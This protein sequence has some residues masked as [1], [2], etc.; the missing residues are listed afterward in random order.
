MSTTIL[1]KTKIGYK[2]LA[3][4]VIT[5]LLITAAAVSAA[6][7]AGA[8][9]TVAF[10][11]ANVAPVLAG[12]EPGAL[13]YAEGAAATSIT[14]NITVADA[15][16]ANMVSATVQITGNYVSTEDVLSFTNA[17]GI[18]GTWDV[19]TGTLTLTGSATKANYQTALRAVKYQN[20]NT[21]APSTTARTLSFTVNDGTVNSN[22][23]SR[24]IN[25]SGVNDAP[26]LSGIEMTNLAYSEGQA[27]T[28][29]TSSIAVSDVDNVNI[30]SATVVISAGF[31]SGKDVLAFTNAFGIT[32]SFSGSTL[33]LSGASSLANY[34]AALQSVTFQNN[35]NNNPSTTTRTI[36]F[37]VNDGA[38][39][40]TTL[41]RNITFTAVNDA[42]VLA[43][44]EAAALTFSEGGAAK[45]ISGAITAVD[46]DNANLTGATIQITGNFV[47]TEDVLSFTTANGITGTFDAATGTIALTG[48]ATVGNYQ[49]AL[50]NVLYK[51]TNTDNPSSSTRTLS[52]TVTDGTDA[53]NT[54]TRNITV[55]PVND[56]S[57]LSAVEPA[58]L[59]YT[60]DQGATTITS[61]L[62]IA[63]VDNTT[64]ASATV[65]INAPAYNASQDVLAFANAFGITGSFNSTTGI[66]TLTGVASLSDYE[67]ALRSVTYENTNH[68]A[69]STTTRAVAF[70]V[71]DGS[72]N[73][74]TMIRN[75]TIAVVND[76]PVL[77]AIESADMAYTEDQAATAMTT[78]QTASDGDNTNL[79]GAT[80]Q[81]T[82]NYVSTED[83]LSF[84]NA[85][86]IT[87]SF[88]ATTGTMTLTGSA[89]VVN[90]QNALRAVRYKNSNLATPSPATRTVSFTVTD[91]SL[92]SNTTTRNITVTPVNDAPTVVADNVTTPEE[93]TITI[94][95]LAN[96]SDV[97]DTI[98][99][100]TLA[101]TVSPVNG[102]ASIDPVNGKITYVPNAEFSGT[103]TIKYT[104]KDVAGTTSLAATV[105]ITVSLINDA[106]SFTIG[107]DQTVTEDF[108]TQTVTGWAT[109]LN[110]GDPFTTQTLTFTATAANTALFA[111]QPAISGT[112]GTLTFK[113]ANN[114][115]GSTTV[116]VTLKDNGSNTAP[117]V[118]ISASQTFTITITAV[119][120]APVGVDDFY[121]T[122]SNSALTANA[123]TNDTDTENN[124]LSLS[125]APLVPPAHGSVVINAVG[126]FTYTPDG[127]FTGTDTF[128]YQVCDN[129]TD[130]GVPASRCGQA[131]VSI[132]VNPP[133]AS[134]NI[135][136]NN[137]I[138]TAPDCFILT[139]ALNNQQGAVWNRKPL[140]LRYSFELN[141]NAI[142]SAPGTVND[143]GADG[144]IWMLQRDD[145]PPPL[146]VAGSPIDARGS[147]GE[148]LGVGGISPGI[149]IEV[150]T[151]Q[152]AGEPAYDHIAI[153]K[154][155]DVYS[156]LASPV[157]ALVDGTNTPLDIE[158]GV[159]H[160]VKMSWDKPS[161][162]F[163][164]YFDGVERISYSNDIVASVFGGDATHVYWGF[165]SSTGG[166]NNYQGVCGITMNTTNLNPVTT[167]DVV[168]VDEDQSVTA[169]FLTNDIDPESGVLT[170]TAET[171]TTTHG[172][173]VINA[174]GTYT[175]TPAHDYNGTDSFTY[176]ICDD[177]STS[178]CTTGTVNI[179]IAPVSDNP[180]ATADAY[181]LNEDVTL[182]V[183]AAGV[184]TNDVDADGD[185]LTALLVSTATHGTLTF[186][187]NGSFSYVPA[188]DY[189][190]TDSF[191]Y[192]INDG[193]NN[194]NIV[195]VSLTINPVN[196]APAAANDAPTVQEDSQVVISVLAN[197]VD[198]DNAIDATS[199][200]LATLP[201]HGTAVL[202]ATTGVVTY[203]PDLNYY[204]TDSFTY[205]VNDATGATSNTATTNI[206][207]TPVN[208]V[209]VAFNDNAVL[210]EDTPT[211]I[212]VLANDTDVDNSLAPASVH[213]VSAAA[214]GTTTLDATTGAILYTPAKDYFG[215]DSFTYTVKDV[216]GGVS[217]V[218]TISLD[219]HP[220]N[221]APV[222][223]ND[224]VG[225]LEETAVIITILANDS[226]VD[227]A[228]DASTVTLVDAPAHGTVSIDNVSGKITY[229]PSN[230][231]LG[232]DAF[233][234]T[235]SDASGAASNVA[236]VNVLVTPPNRKPNAVDDGPIVHKFLIPLAIDVLANDSDVDN[237]QSELTLV[238]VTQPQVGSVSIV[239]G[240]VVYQPSGTESGV[241]TFTYTISDPAGLTDEATVTIEYVYQPLTVSEG[242]SPNNDG[243][244]DAWY[245]RSIE[246]FPNNSIKVFDRWGLLV[247]QASHYNNTSVIWD[248]RSNAGQE[249]GKL[250]DQGTY[251]YAL[252]LGEETK[253][254]S[255]YVMI[256]R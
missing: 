110:D 223:V 35:N 221:D 201:A 11:P 166:K 84:T 207:V 195:T 17:S 185:V 15:D 239:D 193:V 74:N 190:G 202:N 184:L 244:N 59:S 217:N 120:D 55:T 32:G 188:A 111:T 57:V 95:V 235:I 54:V 34:Q 43:A 176:Q 240:K 177:F 168:A 94:D 213:V 236:A 169:S 136:G 200:T 73:S 132:T 230:A 21:D 146:N 76:A 36:T 241:V 103:N 97:D 139:K 183:A 163:K 42:P 33:T 158:D 247:Y 233:S 121:S 225:T 46:V 194:S 53:S 20:T 131:V 128:T 113:P 182:N 30:A 162:T 78:T 31:E 99:P 115:N 13:A 135:V 63:D 38:T 227:N 134:Y 252:S 3:G 196:D 189:N 86:G 104:V 16:N 137:S 246:S 178:G 44:I 144:I 80:I 106:P 203:M 92:S 123:R 52:I 229:T 164:V 234:Y 138:E 198:V 140:D 2:L 231:Y 49:T 56:V 12:I 125:P 208:D 71:N 41:S 40:S 187:A 60:E 101:I 117:N 133:N 206:T 220:V 253:S 112:T 9:K 23:V 219:V 118:N 5:L 211:T 10:V 197:D 173:V 226:D 58:A 129:G 98:D 25:V 88:N 256:V 186:N 130:N 147:V 96:D 81:I 170:A 65:Q 127:S 181:P 204:G 102:T 62:A 39:N 167:N 37:R 154:D 216:D 114:A 27:A 124:T 199:V 122:S 100:T 7:L 242:F 105:T 156:I 249:S 209:P 232:G 90:Y 45:N 18:T 174:D 69:P 6:P 22:T 72:G 85:S 126:T 152:N 165:S 116:T 222:A 248:G 237:T 192:K 68:L 47:A 4:I 153:S 143:A 215:A 48:T 70:R 91:G 210:D 243:N 14:A 89:S 250:L 141:F 145:T 64:L 159:E 29:I 172:S 93:T 87:G 75:I 228:L 255:G 119:N 150:D 218:V 180:V 79:A 238:S 155:G 142:F 161:N 151:Y 8:K 148:Y 212:D 61:T 171:K 1:A 107:A 224:N 157:P 205:T 179:T 175:Y 50:R 51:N 149:G 28:Q 26:V 67:A 83:V 24:N 251:F 109:N 254:I 19:S 108:G 245:I 160:T 191:T 66:L 82:G 214:H 77:A